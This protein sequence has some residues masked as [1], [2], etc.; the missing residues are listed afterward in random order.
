[1]AQYEHITGERLP[2]NDGKAKDYVVLMAKLAL[3]TPDFVIMQ[4]LRALNGRP[5]SPLYD[6]FWS[7]LKIILGSHARVDDRRHDKL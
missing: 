1:M 5:E 4:D 2:K 6:A 3:N 7:E